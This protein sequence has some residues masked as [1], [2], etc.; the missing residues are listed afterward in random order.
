MPSPPGAVF[1]AV[2]GPARLHPQ[3]YTPV[4]TRF[5]LPTRVA[6]QIKGVTL[7][8][9]V[10]PLCGGGEENLSLLFVRCGIAASLW[11][12]I[13]RWLQVE[14]FVVNELVE[15]LRWCDSA[16]LGSSSRHVLEVVCCT[17]LWFIWR[18]RNDVVH[19]SKD[20]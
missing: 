6:L 19:N 8:S 7:D 3:R 9:V 16:R 15:I 14:H 11:G 20:L 5:M 4:P 1:H 10:C 12:S 13:V 17:T 2:A 18:F